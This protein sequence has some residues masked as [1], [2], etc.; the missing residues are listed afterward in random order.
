M[1]SDVQGRQC[2]GV[3]RL[4][5]RIEEDAG[6]GRCDTAA[7]PCHDITSTCLA[8]SVKKER[9]GQKPQPHTH[10]PQATAVATGW[11]GRLPWL[12][13]RNGGWLVM[14]WGLRKPDRLIAMR[15]QCSECPSKAGMWPATDNAPPA[16][17][18]S[19]VCMQP[20]PPPGS[21]SLLPSSPPSPWASP[22]RLPLLTPQ[23]P[24]LASTLFNSLNCQPC[25]FAYLSH[26]PLSAHWT[27][28]DPCAR[29]MPGF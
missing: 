27:R 19:T 4:P 21:G 22:G 10:A 5:G 16:A 24:P 13:L 9:A 6:V 25:P 3:S 26:P 20:P 17:C 12:R 11:R 15:A 7:T 28:V 18:A 1:P 8:C 29:R 14:A 2:R 23:Q